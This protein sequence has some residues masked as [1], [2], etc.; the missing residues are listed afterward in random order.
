ML[1]N[2]QKYDY[3]VKA[4][5]IVE[6]GWTKNNLE[7]NM[8]ACTV[9]AFNK[10]VSGD[11]YGAQYGLE[12]EKSLALQRDFLSALPRRFITAQFEKGQPAGDGGLASVEIWNDAPWRR[13]STVVRMLKKRIRKLAP[14][15]REEEIV[16][17]RAVVAQ[18]RAEI[19]TLKNKVRELEA[20]VQE[21]EN[22]NSFLR[23][24]KIQYTAEQLRNESDAIRELDKELDDALT[25]LRG[26]GVN[27]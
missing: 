7:D 10:A 26:Y 23:K 18:L 15:A 9:G 3:Y 13:K 4:L 2:K 24:S 27:A 8:G 11:A 17:L 25:K 22:Q 20:R 1:T 6:A 19:A 5:Q 14:L 16:R 21:L 12:G